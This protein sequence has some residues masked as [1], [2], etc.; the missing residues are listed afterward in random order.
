MSLT[1][2]TNLDYMFNT[3]LTMLL[4]VKKPTEWILVSGQTWWGVIEVESSYLWLRNRWGSSYWRFWRRCRCW[5]SGIFVLFAILW[6]ADL[7]LV[8]TLL[9][10]RWGLS[11]SGGATG[12]WLSRRTWRRWRCFV[13]FGWKKE[14][15]QLRNHMWRTLGVLMVLIWSAK[16]QMYSTNINLSYN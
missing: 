14:Q 15:K 13:P 12:R 9:A 7:W 10:A 4:D 2:D 5:R 1:S 3:L 8:V 11:S 6:T 16:F